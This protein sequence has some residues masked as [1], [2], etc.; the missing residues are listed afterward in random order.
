MTTKDP[1]TLYMSEEAY[2]R[3]CELA[4]EYGYLNVGNQTAKGIARFIEDVLADA[5]LV[6]ERPPE[7]QEEDAERKQNGYAGVW[8]MYSPRTRRRMK[9][10]DDSLINA[11]A[12]AVRLGIA[13]THPGQWLGA[14][15]FV[16]GPQCM[17]LL[18]EAI[19]SDWIGIH[20]FTAR[21]Q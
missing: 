8:Q 17:S 6:D 3:L 13:S 2:L 18:L 4:T 14:P 1:T 12:W 11:S 16:E 15:Q 10:S 20:G 5:R 7:M 21:T 19:G 9:L